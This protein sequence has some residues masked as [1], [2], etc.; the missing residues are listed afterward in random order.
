[1]G[2][3]RLMANEWAKYNININAIAPGYMATENTA[4]IRK[5]QKEVMKFWKGYRQED[6]VCRMI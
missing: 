2:I 5:T 6:G 1:M 3:T 4:P